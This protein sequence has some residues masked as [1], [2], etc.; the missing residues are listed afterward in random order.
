LSSPILAGITRDS[1]IKI[2]RDMGQPV[3]ET[4]FTRDALYISNEVFFTGTAA[5]ITPVREIDNRALGT[6]K[7]GPIAT[8]VQQAYFRAVRGQEPRYAEWLTYV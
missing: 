5:E 3:E 1:V 8:A 7:V 2:L 6:G 4:T